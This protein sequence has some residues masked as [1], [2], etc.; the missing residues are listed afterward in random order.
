MQIPELLKYID[1]AKSWFV[2]FKNKQ[3]QDIFLIFTATR[4]P[5][6]CIQC[7]VQWALLLITYV[8]VIPKLRI[9]GAV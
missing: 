1:C 7:P 5:L 2:R 9:C 6:G 4:L 3:G 8:R